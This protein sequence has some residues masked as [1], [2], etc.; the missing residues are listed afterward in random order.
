MKDYNLIFSRNLKQAR[1][2]RMLSRA[3]LEKLSNVP[4]KRIDQIERDAADCR[5]SEVICLCNALHIEDFKKMMSEDLK[6]QFEFVDN[7]GEMLQP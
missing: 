5:M 4:S 3:D 7:Y 1:M 6:V 2:A